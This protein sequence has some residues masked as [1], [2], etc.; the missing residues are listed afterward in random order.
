MPIFL[1]VHSINTIYLIKDIE[2]H[3]EKEQVYQDEILQAK[4]KIT[5]I[6][7]EDG[8]HHRLI[9]EFSVRLEERDQIHE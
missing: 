7:D 6:I 1:D 2:S 9:K 4:E 8:K 3:R 5:R